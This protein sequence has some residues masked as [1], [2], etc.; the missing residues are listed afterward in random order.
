MAGKYNFT[1]KQGATFGFGLVWKDSD[2]DLVDLTGYTARMQLR[3]G[4]VNGDVAIEL[5]T[6]DD[7]LSIDELTS[8]VIVSISAEQAEGILAKPCVYDL[9]MVKGDRVVRLLEGKVKI[10]AEVTR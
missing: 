7:G 8:S 6:E 5:T 2:G 1:I 3:Y 10:S 4:S 9:E